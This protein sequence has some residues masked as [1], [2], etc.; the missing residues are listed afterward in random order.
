M[1]G[2]SRV[3][4]ALPALNSWPFNSGPLTSPTMHL[5]CLPACRG[6]TAPHPP[7]LTMLIVMRGT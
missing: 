1:L 5:A 3:A 4:N 2:V 7:S 6:T